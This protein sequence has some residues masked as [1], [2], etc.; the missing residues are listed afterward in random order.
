MFLNETN[1]CYEFSCKSYECFG[2]DLFSVILLFQQEENGFG[3]SLK[4][5]DEQHEK[6]TL[7]NGV[8]KKRRFVR[9]LNSTNQQTSTDVTPIVTVSTSYS[10]HSFY[11]YNISNLIS[12]YSRASSTQD[13]NILTILSTRSNSIESTYQTNRI[14]STGLVTLSTP[15]ILVSTQF[16]Y[17]KTQDTKQL[18]ILNFQDADNPNSNEMNFIT[19]MITTISLIIVLAVFIST[20]KFCF[21]LSNRMHFRRRDSFRTSLL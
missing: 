2:N 11:D 6:E 13:Q 18:M 12:V 17:M 19:Y 7:S 8:N 9:D 1:R 3:I 10:T 5:S 21:S 4:D 16:N 14:F 20:F 15:V